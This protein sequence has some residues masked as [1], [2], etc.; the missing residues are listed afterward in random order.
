LRAVFLC[1]LPLVLGSFYLFLPI[2]V[3][4]KVWKKPVI[5]M[6]LKKKP[7][8]NTVNCRIVRAGVYV[9]LIV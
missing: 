8:S 6:E 7:G 3:W 2:F 4:K 9:G 1:Q 5:A